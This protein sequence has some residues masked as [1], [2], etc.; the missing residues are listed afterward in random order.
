MVGMTDTIKVFGE[1]T[2]EYQRLEA[3][4]KLVNAEFDYNNAEAAVREVYFDFGGG[5]MWT[6]IV[7]GDYQALD[8]LQHAKITLGSMA[9]FAGAVQD[10]IQ[11]HRA[12]VNLLASVR[13]GVKQNEQ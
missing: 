4:A 11:K 8:P 5:V 1:R 2:R 13:Y 3:A 12:H 7:I 10:V 9:D 6:T